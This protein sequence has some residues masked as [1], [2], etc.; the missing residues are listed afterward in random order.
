M[1]LRNIII[2][3][4]VFQLV[5][6]SIFYIWKALKKSS[7]FLE[8]FS[9]AKIKKTRYANLI[10]SLDFTC[11]IQLQQTLHVCRFWQVC[12]SSIQY[13]CINVVARSETIY[14][15][16]FIPLIE[17]IFPKNSCL[18]CTKVIKNIF[19]F[20]VKAILFNSQFKRS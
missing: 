10:L 20:H 13:L 14:C 16:L 17:T 8:I 4:L 11:R 3:N 18:N 6:F 9:G 15:S 1:A 7:F 19:L 5:L 2:L 12:I